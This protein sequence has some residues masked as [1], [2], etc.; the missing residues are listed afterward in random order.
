MAYS[1]RTCKK[2]GFRNI[3]PNMR[4]EKVEYE[5]GSS[6]AGLSTRAVVGSVLFQSDRSANQVKNW[7][8]GNT[9]RQYNRKSLVWVCANGCNNPAPK[10]TS[11]SS[12]S[13]V[14]PLGHVYE[15]HDDKQQLAYDL[16][17]TDDRFGELELYL[18]DLSALR[19]RAGDLGGI[20]DVQAR[21]LNAEL[22]L[23]TRNLESQA[24]RLG[25]IYYPSH[26][27][28]LEKAKKFMFKTAN[29]IMWCFGLIA[30]VSIT[31]FGSQHSL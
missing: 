30:I 16:D 7:M 22:R 18:Q 6:Q 2:C 23:I 15:S 5:V 4:Q 3:Q 28:P 19:E 14:Q 10:T 13:P 8:S 24:V 20:S 25:Y 1:K 27:S 17:L 31:F 11:Q 21:K 29:L 12:A 9:K 26:M